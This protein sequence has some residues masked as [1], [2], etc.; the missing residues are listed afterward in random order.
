MKTH[1]QG[2]NF[3]QH[4]PII[5][6]LTLAFLVRIIGI[7]FGL[8]DLYHA[9][10]PIIVNHALAYGTGDLNPHFFKVPPLV[11]YLLFMCYGVY[12]ALG[13][14]VGFF[15]ELEDF[16]NLFLTDPTNFYLIGRIIFGVLCGTATIYVFY[17]LL[18]RFF[19]RS[20]ALLGSFFLAF[21]FLHVRD[22]HYIY[23]D[24][25]LLLVLV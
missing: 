14:A 21:A 1:P 24:T 16:Q 11:S 20:H 5:A 23:A 13:R 2:P 19:S 22:S 25:P 4:I 15:S 8:P 7:N 3:V 9:D 17:R 6:I 12:F 18:N 10:E